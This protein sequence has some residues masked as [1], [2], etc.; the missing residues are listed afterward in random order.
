MLQ[1]FTRYSGSTVA[2]NSA[3]YG[4]ALSIRE[5]AIII[6]NSIFWANGE[7]SFYSAAGNESSMVTVEYSNF[8]GGEEYL[9][10]SS[11]I[12]LNWGLEILILIQCFAVLD[13]VILPFKKILLFN[14]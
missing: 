10:L 11:S 7:N 14:C 9:S 5:S 8:Y 1:R 2:G 13:R 12:I 3:N 6:K 4:S